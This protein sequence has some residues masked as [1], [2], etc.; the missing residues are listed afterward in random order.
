LRDE[1]GAGR[2]ADDSWIARRMPASIIVER[3]PRASIDDDRGRDTT[4]VVTVT[5]RRLALFRAATPTVVVREPRVVA[6]AASL[7]QLR[8]KTT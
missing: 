2:D 6:Q 3:M 8:K 1:N 7:Q 4:M 5:P